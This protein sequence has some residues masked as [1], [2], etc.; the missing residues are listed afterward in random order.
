MHYKLKTSFTLIPF[1]IHRSLE[2][3]RSEML[4]LAYFANIEET[5]KTLF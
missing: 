2:I 4:P 5:V 3:D 1:R